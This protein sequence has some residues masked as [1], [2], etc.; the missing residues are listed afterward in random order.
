MS[1]ADLVVNYPR[2]ADG[3]AI[4]WR[5]SRRA[6][7][8]GQR[9]KR[10]QC[11]ELR[12]TPRIIEEGRGP[13]GAVSGSCGRKGGSSPP[14][15]APSTLP[16]DTAPTALTDWS[17]RP[18]SIRSGQN[19]DPCD[20]SSRGRLGVS[21]MPGTTGLYGQSNLSELNARQQRANIK[22][23]R[24]N[25]P[26]P[27]Y[28]RIKSPARSSRRGPKADGEFRRGRYRDL[29]GPA[30]PATPPRASAAVPAG[31]G[32]ARRYDSRCRRCPWD[33]GRRPA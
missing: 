19:R 8:G 27:S 6:I 32:H 21:S 33:G 22:P 2:V 25:A 20:R 17:G 23:G 4:A 15:L 31:P 29:R 24:L 7:S 13:I 10:Q 11:Q 14:P 9:T 16:H 30:F 5:N 12:L 1:C 26:R 18:A 28:W 3:I